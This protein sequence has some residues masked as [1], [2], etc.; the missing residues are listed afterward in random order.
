MTPYAWHQLIDCPVTATLETVPLRGRC[1]RGAVLNARR[2]QC[3]GWVD[4]RRV[5]LALG[6]ALVGCSVASSTPCTRTLL[7]GSLHDLRGRRPSPRAR[8]LSKVRLPSSGPSGPER[9]HRERVRPSHTYRHRRHGIRGGLDRLSLG[10]SGHRSDRHGHLQGDEA[11][12]AS[13]LEAQRQRF[14]DHSRQQ[15][16]AGRHLRNG[17]HLH[18]AN[19][20]GHLPGDAY[21]GRSEWIARYRPSWPTRAR[22]AAWEPSSWPPTGGWPSRQMPSL[23]HTA[24]P[25]R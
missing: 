17:L 13:D 4:C 19:Q 16:T 3:L 7:F 9:R 20:L 18:A 2:A 12:P 15:R 10:L 1:E 5:A 14:F 11:L 21:R 24:T 8:L 22:Q 25:S 6:P 23:G